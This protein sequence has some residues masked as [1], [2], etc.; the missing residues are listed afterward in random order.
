[1]RASHTRGFTLIELLVVISIIALLIALLL[2]SLGTARK[3]AIRAKCL[4]ERRQLGVSMFTFSADHR[5]LAPHPIEQWSEGN[6]E[7]AEQINWERHENMHLYKFDGGPGR[8]GALGTIAGLGY[9]DAPEPLFCPAYESRRWDNEF[10]DQQNNLHRSPWR[11]RFGYIK[12]G[13]DNYGGRPA[14]PESPPPPRLK[15]GVAHLLTIKG[16]W[17]GQDLWNRGYTKPNIR[18]DDFADAPNDPEVSPFLAACANA[19]S[20]N[21][22]VPFDAYI[23]GEGVAYIPDRWGPVLDDTGRFYWNSHEFEGV[24]V[25]GYDGSGRWVSRKEVP[26]VG[27][28]NNTG[29]FM[30]NYYAISGNFNVWAQTEATLAA[31]TGP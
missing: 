28:H 21:P 13:A 30:S 8:T 15:A 31:P 26:W 4:A 5:G 22:P 29:H 17:T 20:F 24:N 25:V 18:M 23:G 11:S 27:F 9:L 7:P 6:R 3:L 16:P 14:G 1:M 12:A 10:T 2:P 19:A